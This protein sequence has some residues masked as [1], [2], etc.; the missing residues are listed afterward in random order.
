DPYLTFGVVAGVLPEQD[1]GA[2][3]SIACERPQRLATRGPGSLVG[4]GDDAARARFYHP[5]RE[6]TDQ[7]VLP[8]VLGERRASCD[9]EV[10]PEAVH[11]PRLLATSGQSLVEVGEG[12]LSDDEERVRVCESDPVGGAPELGV[13]AAHRAAWHPC[14]VIASTEEVTEPLS[15]VSG[16]Q[17][18][19]DLI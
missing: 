15:N 7:H 12:R 8:A 4:G 11:G 3:T 10:R 16:G 6:V 13:D 17:H 18:G 2:P 14:Q 5:E 1:L 9:D 19:L